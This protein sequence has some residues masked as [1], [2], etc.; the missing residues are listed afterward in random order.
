MR[1]SLDTN[2]PPVQIGTIP[3]GILG[4]DENFNEVRGFAWLEGDILA[5]VTDTPYQVVRVDVRNGVELGRTDIEFAKAVQPDQVLAAIDA[6]RFLLSVDHYDERGYIQDTMW[7]DAMTGENGV[8]TEGSPIAELI[9]GNRMLLSRG[10]TLYLAGY[11]PE[12]RRI[13]GEATPVF[14]NLRTTN[15]WSGGGFDVAGDGTVGHLP[16]GLQGGR[17]TLWRIEED[18]TSTALETPARAYEEALAV[19]EDGAQIVIT[20]T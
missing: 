15:S 1:L 18:G 4:Y 20:K 16:G 14:T 13:D 7:V 3:L 2:L 8:V 9:D 10:E 17:R 5:F 12:T 19:S 11:D 6:N